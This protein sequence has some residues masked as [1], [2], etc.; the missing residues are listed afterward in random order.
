MTQEERLSFC[1]VCKNRKSNAYFE[2]VCG[3]TDKP[4]NFILSCE[5]FEDEMQ[6]ANNSNLAYNSKPK[7][8]PASIEK[9]FANFLLDLIFYFAFSIV[10]GMVLGIL[11]VILAPDSLYIFDEDN[12]LVNYLLGF[13]AGM[14][15]FTTL[16]YYTGRTIA[17]YITKTK[18]VTEN[19]EKPKLK[20]VL[21]RSACR[22]IPFEQLSFFSSTKSGLHD[23]LSKTMVVDS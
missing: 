7:L 1:A 6:E 16:E 12:K 15:Y 22:F 2:P 11:L 21:I 23:V 20:T 5:S 3:L 14:I 9:R 4:A 13:I 17:K 8:I 19:G 10:F 18:V